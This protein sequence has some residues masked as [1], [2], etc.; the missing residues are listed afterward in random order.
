[1]LDITILKNVHIP[2]EAHKLYPYMAKA[3]VF[4]V[5]QA[6]CPERNA[7]IN[8]NRIARDLAK[9]RS[10]KRKKRGKFSKLINEDQPGSFLSLVFDE[11]LKNRTYF[12][13]IERFHESSTIEG[14]RRH[15]EVEDFY[16]EA[17]RLL[18]SGKPKEAVEVYLLGQQEGIRELNYRDR[19]IGANLDEAEYKIRKLS[20]SLSRKNPIKFFVQIGASHRPEDYTELPVKVIDLTEDSTDYYKLTIKSDDLL[21]EG[22]DNEEVR[23]LILTTN[24]FRLAKNGMIQ[25]DVSKLTLEQMLE[26]SYNELTN[27][28]KR[29]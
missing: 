11:L 8:E 15:A 17:E 27:L 23:Q 25:G 13:S 28:L 5:E 7:I 19:H 26:L 20:R 14:D 12:Y 21:R 22:L 6:Y 4:S 10:S 3:D 2:E 9:A 29:K 24:A 18:V 1:M 16:R